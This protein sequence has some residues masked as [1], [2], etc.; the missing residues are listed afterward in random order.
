MRD[1]YARLEEQLMTAASHSAERGAFGRAVAGRRPQLPA[2]LA[3]AATVAA[4]LAFLPGAL[5]P[6]GATTRPAPSASSRPAAPPAATADLSGIRVAVFNAT[7]RPGLAREYADRLR[8]R[9]A[10]IAVV[11]N[12]HRQ[13]TDVVDA[14]GYRPDAV[15]L[16]RRVA[17][18]LRVPH[19]SKMNGADAALARDAKV[20]VVLGAEAT[21]RKVGQG[22]SGTWRGGGPALTR[23][24]KRRP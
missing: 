6:T 11:A 23:R 24:P 16:A 21:R 8:T 14:V 10:V 3:V 18:V 9:G 7:L 2:A 1:F 15:A 20:V 22:S 5:G 13:G 4:G 19:V 12:Y 17:A